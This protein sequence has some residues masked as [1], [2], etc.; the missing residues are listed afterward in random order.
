MMEG[1]SF[2]KGSINML[3][4]KYGFIDVKKGFTCLIFLARDGLCGLGWVYMILSSLWIPSKL[5]LK[6]TNGLVNL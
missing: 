1:N 5:M 2:L 6:S 3:Q 4:Y